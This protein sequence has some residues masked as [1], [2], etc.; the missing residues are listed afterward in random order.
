MLSH[1]FLDNFRQATE[2]R[3]HNA[4]VNPKVYGFQFQPGTSWNAGLN[5]EEIDAY[6]EILKI[7]FPND[8]KVFLSSMN[9]TSPPTVNIHGSSEEP[10]SL[11]VGVYSYPD[12]LEIVQAQIALITDKMDRKTLAATLAEEGFYLPEDANL[13]PI[14]EH[15]YIVCIPL[16][17]SSTVLSIWDENDA[18]VYGRSLQEYL[19]EEFLRDFSKHMEPEVL[20]IIGEEAERNGTS[21]L[22]ESQIEEIIQE[23]RS[24]LR[25]KSA[26]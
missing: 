2:V 26:N 16:Q 11:S 15:R 22:T 18:I 6:Q 20:R 1:E 9:G 3:W 19:E 8:F 5:D 21:K 14:F 23:Y 4:S 13:M 7:C 10:P 25:T 24:E 17:D 12:D